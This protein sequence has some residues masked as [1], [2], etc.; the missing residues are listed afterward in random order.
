[1]LFQQT[2]TICQQTCPGKQGPLSNGPNIVCLN[3]KTSRT[4]KLETLNCLTVTIC[5]NVGSWANWG[6]NWNQNR[7]RATS[8]SGWEFND[9]LKLRR[10]PMVKTIY[11]AV[12]LSVY[13]E[14]WLAAYQ[15]GICDRCLHSTLASPL[16]LT[17]LLTKG[18]ATALLRLISMLNQPIRIPTQCCCLICEK[19]PS[20]KCLWWSW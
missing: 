11:C 6:F 16:F 7:E 5:P 15:S 1:M 18:L 12:N 13:P 2:T 3:E 8:R 17:L 14:P 4:K 20:E 9:L 19:L 10:R